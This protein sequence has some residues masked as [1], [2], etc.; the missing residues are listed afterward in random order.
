M[1][2]Y[3]TTFT[4]LLNLALGSQTDLLFSFNVMTLPPEHRCLEVSILTIDNGLP[5]DIEDAA[6][7]YCG[8]F[9]EESFSINESKGVGKELKETACL[10]RLIL[11]VND[12]Q[13]CVASLTSYFQQKIKMSNK[14]RNEPI[15]AKVMVDSKE[16]YFVSRAMHL[17]KKEASL[18][19]IEIVKATEEQECEIRLEKGVTSIDEKR[20][21]LITVPT[22]VQRIGLWRSRLTLAFH[23]LSNPVTELKTRIGKPMEPVFNPF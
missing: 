21:T 23:W 9:R 1:L 17:L 19:C 6:K 16:M 13:E 14:V 22:R 20:G 4:L 18:F 3:F 15:F 8:Q 12:E 10:W 7:V 11:N 5:F 2:L